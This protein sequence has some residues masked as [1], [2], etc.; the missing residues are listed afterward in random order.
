[1]QTLAAGGAAA[2]AAVARRRIGEAPEC[3]HLAHQHRCV[4]T[5]SA[6]KREVLLAGGS[7]LLMGERSSAAGASGS[8]PSAPPQPSARPA[9]TRDTEPPAS[10][11]A[12]EA[13]SEDV[14]SCDSTGGPRAGGQGS[15][16]RR[17]PRIP[18]VQ[19]GPL[20]VSKVSCRGCVD[21]GTPAHTAPWRLPFGVMPC[22]RMCRAAGGAWCTTSAD[23]QLIMGTQ[24]DELFHGP[25]TAG[26]K[27]C[28]LGTSCCHARS[29]LP[30][31]RAGVSPCK[32]RA[33]C[34]SA[35]KEVTALPSVQ[36]LQGHTPQR[37]VW[38]VLCGT[39]HFTRQAQRLRTPCRD[40]VLLF[41]PVRMLTGD[42]G[43][44][45]AGRPAPW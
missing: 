10:V 16:R 4:S 15:A 23:T 18:R 14:E 30:G 41:I 25:C 3:V 6:R 42:S 33:D 26:C 7:I 8:P 29:K 17:L 32:H 27:S 44:L 34:S 35:H 31:A 1:M 5:C 45:A 22:R 39:Q 19:L 24:I 28:T 20:V 21:P 37:E 36:L 13:S 9:G 38:P 43:L 2:Y 12:R 40:P 11:D